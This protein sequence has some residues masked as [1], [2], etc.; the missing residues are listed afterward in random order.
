MSTELISQWQILEQRCKAL[1]AEL[2]GL[3]KA[4]AVLGSAFDEVPAYWY[5]DA[6]GDEHYK[7][8]P[9][10]VLFV[11]LY[12][13]EC[14]DWLFANG[15]ELTSSGDGFIFPPQNWQYIAGRITKCAYGDSNWVAIK[16]QYEAQSAL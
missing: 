11:S 7:N 5:V 2:K 6:Y 3:R 15:Y 10:A 1:E 13:K 14:V 4:Q 9:K 8:N 16:K 12:R